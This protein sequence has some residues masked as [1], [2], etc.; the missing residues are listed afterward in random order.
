LDIIRNKDFSAISNKKKDGKIAV[1]Y[2]EK[3][4]NGESATTIQK[5]FLR[6]S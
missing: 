5:S 6:L 3:V 2:A 1:V 4:K